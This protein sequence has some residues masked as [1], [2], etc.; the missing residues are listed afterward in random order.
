[1]LPPTLAFEQIVSKPRLNS[2]RGYWGVDLDTAVGLYMW[3]GEV[4]SELSKLLSYLEISLRNNI[5]REM[6]LNASGGATV[7]CHWWDIFATQLK[8]EAKKL[9]KRVRDKSPHAVLSPDEIVSRLTFGFWPNMLAWV[10]KQRPNVATKVLPAHPLSQPGA[11]ATWFDAAARHDATIKFLEFSDARNRIAHHEPLWKFADV[12]DT[13]P[14]A[15]LPP[16]LVCAASTDEAST[17]GRFQ[18]LLQ[19]Y[20]ESMAHL[21]PALCVSLQASS[22]RQKLDFLLSSRGLQRYKDGMYIAHTASMGTLALSQQFAS[23]VQQNRPVR[24]LDNG[25]TGMFIPG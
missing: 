14:V 24:L 9:V 3:N 4:C 25:G 6:S 15:P 13:S 2:Y 20:D 5:H 7:T 16:I 17:L 1:M 22:W 12:M 18:R 23:V 11:A 8:P 21:S 10:A 19:L